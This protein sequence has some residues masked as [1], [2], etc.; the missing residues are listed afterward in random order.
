MTQW[1]TRKGSEMKRGGRLLVPLVLAALIGAAATAGP[2]GS[3]AGA[4][5]AGTKRAVIGGKVK[6]LRSGQSCSG[7]YQAAYK[8]YG[9]TCVSGHLR[10][11]TTTT[12]PPPTP[13]PPAPPPSPPPP[14]AQPGHYHGTDSQNEVID[15][16]VTADG[17]GVVNLSTGQINEGCTPTAYI[18]GGNIRGASAPVSSDGAFVLDGPYQGKFNDGTSYSGHFNLTGHFSGTTATGTISDSLNFTSNGTAYS[19]GSG[20]QTWTATRTG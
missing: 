8:K 12:T 3:S 6:C 11:R 16:D 13:E 18:Y 1:N 20:Q 9:F 19:C 17:R 14:P 5:R 7:R 15:F 4:C 2:A 10:K